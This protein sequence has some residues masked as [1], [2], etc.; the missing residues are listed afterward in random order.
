MHDVTTD[1]IHHRQAARHL[2]AKAYLASD[3]WH[4]AEVQAT[5]LISYSNLSLIT[6]SR[7][8]HPEPENGYASNPVWNLFDAQS[9]IMD[10]KTERIA[11][12]HTEQWPVQAM[13]G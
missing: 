12:I 1:D 4:K 10:E 13:T 9:M 11:L 8:K 2:L 5:L 6:H 3:C 7:F